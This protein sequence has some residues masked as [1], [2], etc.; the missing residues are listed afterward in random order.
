MLPTALLSIGRDGKASISLVYYSKD[1][2]NLFAYLI[3]TQESRKGGNGNDA[4]AKRN[5]EALQQVIDYCTNTHC[6][7]Q[8]VLKH[9][10]EKETD[11]K[12]VCQKACDYC[13]NPQKVERT[14]QSSVAAR[15]ISFQRKQSTRSNTTFDGQWGKP[16]GDDEFFDAEDDYTVGG[17]RITSSLNGDN[18][19]PVVIE[20]FKTAKSMIDWEELEKEEVSALY[21]ISYDFFFR[22]W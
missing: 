7:R 16:H 20:G 19:V 18:D 5:Q 2:A 11:P 14:I 13:C 17:L 1:D 4:T 21:L 22:C 8:Y 6:R 3:R 9:F 15:T 12:A 10:G